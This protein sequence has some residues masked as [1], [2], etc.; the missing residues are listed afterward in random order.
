MQG[1][2]LTAGVCSLA[3]IWELH[4]GLKGGAS[5]LELKDVSSRQYMKNASFW[6]FHQRQL[7][8]H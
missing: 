5:L 8:L 2:T 3:G 1:L 6:H 7:N 4:L